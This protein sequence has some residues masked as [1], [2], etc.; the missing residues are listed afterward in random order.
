MTKDKHQFTV[1]IRHSCHLCDDMLTVLNE[2]LKS[3]LVPYNL[4]IVDIANDVELEAKF[5][6]LVPVL[7]ES[8]NEICHYFFDANQWHEYFS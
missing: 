3:H 8:G 6:Q 2:Y 7:H 5:G 4:N 1:Y